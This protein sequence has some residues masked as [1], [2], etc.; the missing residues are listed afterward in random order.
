MKRTLIFLTLTL[1]P[2]PACQSVPA[3]RENNCACNWKALDHQ[4]EGA[5]T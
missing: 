2:L 3:V 1:V 4:A 5:V